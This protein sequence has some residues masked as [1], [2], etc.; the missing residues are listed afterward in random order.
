M[1]KLVKRLKAAVPPGPAG[2][3]L[4]E[5]WMSKMHAVGLPEVLTGTVLQPCPYIVITN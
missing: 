3:T 1:H 5:G 4:I 2:A